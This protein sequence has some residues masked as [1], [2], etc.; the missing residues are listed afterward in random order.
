MD[1]NKLNIGVDN[2]GASSM[3]PNI[4]WIIIRRLLYNSERLALVEQCSEYD[5]GKPYYEYILYYGHKKLK[6]NSV[7]RDL[8]SHLTPEEIIDLIQREEFNWYMC[9]MRSAHIIFMDRHAQLTKKMGELQ[10]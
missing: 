4:R 7:H 1:I 5:E 9:K 10:I 2:R 8:A 3:H 6:H